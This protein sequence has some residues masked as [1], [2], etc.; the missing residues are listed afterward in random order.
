[1][2]PW[3]LAPLLALPACGGK[4]TADDTAR[5]TASETDADTDAD[6][7]TDTDTDTD[8]DTGEEATGSVSGTVVWE[9]GSPAEGVQVRLCY[10]SCRAVLADGSG[11]FSYENVEAVGQTLQAVVLGDLGYA[12]P[13]ALVVVPA[14]EARTLDDPIVVPTFATSEAL[15]SAAEIAA[16]GGLVIQADPDAMTVGSYT[17]TTDL[18]VASRQ[19]DPS[20]A[21]L[22]FDELDGEVVAMWYLGDFDVTASPAFPFTVSGLDG[23]TPGEQLEVRTLSNEDKAWT[24][25]GTA[26]VGEDG[27]VTSDDGG[28]I[29]HLTTMLLVRPAR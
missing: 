20:A 13:N 8:V 1:M 11:A 4:S 28:G 24:L 18:F 5:D 16:D 15:S 27:T 26:T 29:A 14:D 2:R 22:P 21:G 19:M 3:L 17:P 23:L 12:T 25:D 10:H 9:D 6:A 7:D